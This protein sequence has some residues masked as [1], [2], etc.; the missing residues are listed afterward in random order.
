MIKK[1][2]YDS[3]N[4]VTT[5]HV[6][7]TGKQSWEQRFLVSFD[8]H[9]DSSKSDLELQLKHL[10]QA[11]QCNAGIIDG[12]DLF[13]AMQ[14]RGDK[15]GH[16]SALRPEFKVDN[17]F[18]ALIEEASSFFGPYAKNWI[19]QAT[20]NHE[21][22]VLQYQE[23]DLTARF[24]KEMRK[25][26]PSIV[27]GGYSGFIRFKFEHE[28][29]GVR[30]SCKLFYHHGYGADSPVTKGVIQTNRMGI[31]YPDAD[32]IVTGHNHESWIFPISRYRIDDNGKTYT[33]EQYH[34]KVP[35]YKEEFDKGRGGWHVERG[36]GPKP[37]GAYWLIFFFEEG[38]VKF[39]IER[40][41]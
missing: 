8:R 30:S 36:A 17:Y 32:I 22:K 5:I 38:R 26:N 25:S 27:N 12:G 3:E 16:K 9:F 2:V 35:T 41:K 28:S 20:G 10:K 13:D 1:V 40:A 29:G 18:D 33:D 4:H 37:V 39:K 34:V 23:T 11:K 19:L 21:S 6:S 14:G 31:M 15:R 7:H 24:L